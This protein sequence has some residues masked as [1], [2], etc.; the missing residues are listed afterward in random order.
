MKAKK[1]KKILIEK[2]GIALCCAIGLLLAMSVRARGGATV[3]AG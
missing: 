1:I 2:G 3:G